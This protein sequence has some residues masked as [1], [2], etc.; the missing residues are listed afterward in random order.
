MSLPAAVPLALSS[1]AWQAV[2]VSGESGA[3]KTEAVKIMMNYLAAVSK[4]AEL[5]RVA[6]QVRAS[7]DT[8]SRLR[9]SETIESPAPA[10]L[11]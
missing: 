9:E 6:D 7:P 11:D 4:T 5:N 10:R 1:G 8:A 2:L 3:G